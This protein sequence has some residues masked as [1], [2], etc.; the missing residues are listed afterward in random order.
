M[1]FTC[2]LKSSP[3]KHIT[4]DFKALTTMEAGVGAP[5]VV[6]LS[7]LDQD[8]VKNNED[9]ESSRKRTS[10]M[11]ADDEHNKGDERASS[12]SKSGTDEKQE[13]AEAVYLI[14]F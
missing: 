3:V 1:T 10:M 5:A 7:K 4:E 14:G 6:A 2:T 13:E 9:N 8:I 11:I 12:L